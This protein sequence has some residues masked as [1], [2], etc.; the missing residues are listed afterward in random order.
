MNSGLAGYPQKQDLIIT[1]AGPVNH[2]HVDGH[3]SIITVL[4]MNHSALGY[5]RLYAKPSA[6]FDGVND[7]MLSQRPVWDLSNC[8]E[9]SICFWLYLPTHPNTYSQRSIFGLYSGST[10]QL[11]GRYTTNTSY[12]TRFYVSKGSQVC[13]SNPYSVIHEK[14]NFIAFQFNVNT[15][16]TVNIYING[17]RSVESNNLAGIINPAT[18]TLTFGRSSTSFSFGWFYIHSFAMRFG[19]WSVSELREF[20]LSR[21]PTYSGAHVIYRFDEG[22][23]NE[24]RNS[25]SLTT[26]PS[27]IFSKGSESP[28]WVP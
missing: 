19:L 12:G 5:P 20:Y 21:R 13:Y 24:V 9:L 7:T 4:Q 22:F 16:P 8:S 25:G 17:N 27:L 2:T 28:L 14:W 1:D 23:G 26:F 10:I 11:A 15:N 6:Y 18:Y 3:R